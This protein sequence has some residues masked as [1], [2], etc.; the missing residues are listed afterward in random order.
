MK[1][2][3]IFLLSVIF[4]LSAC[5]KD[6]NCVG[7]VCYHDYACVDGE[8]VCPVCPR[9]DCNYLV[10]SFHSSWSGASSSYDTIYNDTLKI[11]R[12]GKDFIFTNYSSFNLS[13]IARASSSSIAVFSMPNYPG[14]R[15][16]YSVHFFKNDSV[17]AFK[18]NGI[19]GLGSS[20]MLYGTKI[21]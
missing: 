2:S 9:Y 10:T 13:Y 15:T 1:P 3:S 14:N 6:N 7:V 8:C 17:S 11:T 5:Y 12:I 19:P 21:P 16:S 18:Y 4:C 20:S